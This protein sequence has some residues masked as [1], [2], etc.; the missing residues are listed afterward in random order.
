MCH[1]F[2]DTDKVAVMSNMVGEMSGIVVLLSRKQYGDSIRI[3]YDIINILGV[4]L[5]VEAYNIINS[6]DSMHT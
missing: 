2:D 6:C 1:L 4:M 5:Y 3:G